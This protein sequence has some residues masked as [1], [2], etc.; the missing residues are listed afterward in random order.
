MIEISC[1]RLLF[2]ADGV[3]VDSLASVDAAWTRWAHRWDLDPAAVVPIVHG[4][5]SADT[6]ARLV[7]HADRARATADIDRYEVEDAASVTALPGAGELLGS[8][9]RGSWAVVTSGGRRR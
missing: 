8:L 1:S 9:P 5:R 3:L 7:G 6:V 4:R 2:D